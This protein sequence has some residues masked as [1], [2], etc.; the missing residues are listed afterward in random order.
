MLKKLIEVYKI[1]FLISLAIFLLVVLANFDK[2]P[3]FYFVFVFIGAFMVPFLYE[4]D[5]ILYAYILEPTT[6]FSISIKNLLN[7]K[8]Y[9]GVFI[10]AHENEISITSSVFR[11]ILLVISIF[12]VAF[13]SIYTFS[14]IIS[15]TILL[16]FLLT[17]IYLQTI[18]FVNN[19]YRSWYSFLDFVPKITIAKIF[20][21]MQYLVYLLFLLSIF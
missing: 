10:F 20:L 7:Q 17:S 16:T 19:S 3:T 4:L 6:N 18:S 1:Y 21:M 12:A 5:Y 15:Q 14:N 8:N 11:S 2:V 9:K 13:L